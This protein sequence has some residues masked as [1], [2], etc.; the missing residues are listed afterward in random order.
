M[1]PWRAAVV[2]S[3]VL[4][5]PTWPC[6][7]VRVCFQLSRE[8]SG[9]SIDQSPERLLVQPEKEPRSSCGP[10]SACPS[11]RLTLTFRRKL[12]SLPLKET[13]LPHRPHLV[14]KLH[15][16]PRRPGPC[17]LLCFRAC[18]THHVTFTFRV[19]VDCS[20]PEAEVSSDF[21]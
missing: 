19:V 12:R 20:A 13:F 18:S 17:N 14:M 5:G 4:P 11:R 10:C 2:A 3:E 9:Y 15:P 21:L 8:G 7:G 6:P 16:E 1:A